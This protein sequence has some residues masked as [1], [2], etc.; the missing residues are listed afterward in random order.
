MYFERHKAL[1]GE[2]SGELS[3]ELAK[4]FSTG[5]ELRIASGELRVADGTGLL[6]FRLDF[7]EVGGRGLKAGGQD[8]LS[9]GVNSTVAAAL[10]AN[11][12]ARLRREFPV[13]SLQ[14]A[15]TDKWSSAEVL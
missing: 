14:L 4:E 6:G 2:L 7:G 8:S 10:R 11:D 13:P 15:V 1:S 9:S 12:Q 5:H 3:K